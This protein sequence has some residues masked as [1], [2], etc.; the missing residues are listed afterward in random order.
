MSTRAA[1]LRIPNDLGQNATTDISAALTGLLADTFALYLKTKN[2]HWHMSGPHFRDYHLLLD[3]QGDQIFAMT[4][5]IAERARKVGGTTLRSVG[6]IARTQRLLDN[7]AEFVTPEDMIAELAGDNRQMAGY[8]RAT[9]AVAEEHNDVATTSLI[10]VWIDET[11]RRAWF[12]FE[13]GR[14]H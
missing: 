9:H 10:E 13:I 12:L 11:E 2:F 7:D 1:A 3:E 6:H 14:R 8:L 4:D 5:A